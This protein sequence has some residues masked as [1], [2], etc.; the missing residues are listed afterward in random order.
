MK[1][2]EGLHVSCLAQPRDYAVD[3]KQ[4]TA[5]ETRIDGLVWPDGRRQEL[6]KRQ[7]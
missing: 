6:R 1:K 3:E 2:T 7:G 4:E 5:G